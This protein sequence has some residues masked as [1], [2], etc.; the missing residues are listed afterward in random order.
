MSIIKDTL[1]EPYFIE[2]KGV[3]YILKLS[4][5]KLDKNLKSVTT[6]EGYFYNKSAAYR[7]VA[8][9]K[10]SSDVLVRTMKEHNEAEMSIYRQF[11]DRLGE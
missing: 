11:L 6:I 3:Q 5:G 4:T 1:L 2:C 7:M 9:L 8:K 10:V